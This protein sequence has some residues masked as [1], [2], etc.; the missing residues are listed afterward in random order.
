M[1][2]DNP[3]IPE[4]ASWRSYQAFAQRVRHHRRYVW[5][6]DIQAFMDTVI[7]TLK[8]REVSVSANAI[9][10]RAQRGVEYSPILDQD[11]NEVSEEPRG[12]DSNRMKPITNR[13]IEGRVNPAG[14]PILYLAS[15]KQTAISEVRPWIGSEIS[16]AQFKILKNLRA[17]NLTL[18]HSKSSMSHLTLSQILEEEPMD[19][20]TKHKCVWADIDSAF[21]KPVTFSEDTADYVPTQI[22][23]E[24]FKNEGFEAAIYRSHFGKKG[25]NIALFNV[26]DADCINCAPY[27]VKEIEVKYSE[28]GN[29]WYLRKT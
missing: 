13:A 19:A 6:D 3:N 14:I 20:E 26:G 23:T 16:V 8:G 22:L 15:E 17:I 7:A 12:F 21:S 11:G 18:G 10:Y 27:E 24:L 1:H 4:F 9:L 2:I 28:I 5:S 25:H 29:P